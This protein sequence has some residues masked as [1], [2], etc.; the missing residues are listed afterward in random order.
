MTT[1]RINQVPIVNPSAETN[2]RTPKRGLMYRM[3][4]RS[5][6]Y[7]NRKH[8]KRTRRLSHEQPIQLSLLSFPSCGP[9]RVALGYYTIYY[10]GT[11]RQNLDT[12]INLYLAT[13]EHFVSQEC[14]CG[15]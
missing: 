4:T 3:E 2:V 12:F 14:S 15:A 7:P 8:R 10:P 1:G 6:S 13:S 11:G 9:Q 5:R